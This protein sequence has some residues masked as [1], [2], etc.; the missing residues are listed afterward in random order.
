MV[1][2]HGFSDGLL[3]CGAHYTQCS[4]RLF[5]RKRIG[6]GRKKGAA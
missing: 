5:A 3:A 4:P 6:R 2:G 1:V